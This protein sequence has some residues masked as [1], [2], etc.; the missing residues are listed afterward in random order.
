MG[1]QVEGR[2]LRK[3]CGT[4]SQICGQRFQGSS[5]KEGAGM[6]AIF[7]PISHASSIRLQVA[8]ASQLNLDILLFFDAEQEFIR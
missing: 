5:Q 1:V 7:L 8:I 3:D 4:Q 6:K 2:R